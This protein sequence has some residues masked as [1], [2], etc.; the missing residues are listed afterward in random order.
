MSTHVHALIHDNFYPKVQSA[1]LLWIKEHVM[2]FCFAS[3]KFFYWI[4][5]HQD[6]SLFKIL[7]TNNYLVKWS[8]DVIWGCHLE[9]YRLVEQAVCHLLLWLINI[10]MSQGILIWMIRFKQVEISLNAITFSMTREFLIMEVFYV[11]LIIGDNCG[12]FSLQSQLV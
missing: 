12:S 3:L 6:V 2:A 5:C 4:V 9:S 11:I 10:S 1:L 7:Y 8:D